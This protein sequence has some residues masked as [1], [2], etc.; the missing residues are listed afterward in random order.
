ML[1][2]AILVGTAS[3]A[4]ALFTVGALSH[5]YFSRSDLPDLG[6][7]TRFQ[8][9]AIGHIYDVNGRP[10]IE[11]A[12]EYREIVRYADIPPIMRDAILATEDKHFL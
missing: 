6:P 8:F 11:L 9:P 2:C 12:N 10:L 1:T 4:A 3:V 7:F 5:V